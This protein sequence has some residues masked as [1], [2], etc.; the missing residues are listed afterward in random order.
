MG[1]APIV[2]GGSGLNPGCPRV[3]NDL[4]LAWSDLARVFTA[5]RLPERARSFEVSPCSKTA[6]RARPG[7]ERRSGPDLAAP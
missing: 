3:H 6:V 7:G 4:C 5:A 1:P 2:P